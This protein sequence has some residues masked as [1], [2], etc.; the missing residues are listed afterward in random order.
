[1]MNQVRKISLLLAFVFVWGMP[2]YAQTPSDAN[3]DCFTGLIKDIKKVLSENDKGTALAIIEGGVVQR[4]P[5]YICYLTANE[6][7]KSQLL[8]KAEQ[9]R[10]DKQP[11]TTSSSA[12]TTS[13]VSKG[14]SPSL[15][16]FALEHGGFTQTTDGNTI[17]FRGNAVN[18]IR[19]LMKSTY[20]GS[21]ELG[22]KDPLV[23]Y[24]AKL[25]LGISF[26]ASGNQSSTAQGFVPTSNSLSGFSAKYEIYNHRDPRDSRWRKSWNQIV[27][28]LG[29]KVATPLAELDAAIRASPGYHETWETPTFRELE[30]LPNDPM[31]AQIQKVLQ[32]A[33][34]LF[35]EHYWNLLAVQAAVER[36][37]GSTL[38]YLKEEDDLLSSIRKTPL[39]TVEYNFTRQLTTNNQ[40][41]IATQPNQKLP[42]LSNVNLVLEKGLAGANAPELTLNAGGT[43]F[44]SANSADPN[45]GRVRDYRVSLQLDVPLKEIQNIGKPTVSLSG[46]F[47][48]LLNEPLG[49]KV[50][51]N[52][53]AIDRRGNIGVFQA[54]LSVP[55]KDSG[56][57][58][59][60]SFTYAS[61]TEL[62]KE[63]DV[64]GNIGITFDLDTLFSKAK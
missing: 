2:A 26:D 34:D 18:S 11:G 6:A 23:V 36:F 28:S 41:I 3:A 15:F 24:L 5:V 45:R 8:G 1:M 14:S 61:R 33:G 9:S 47:L 4:W 57:K 25:S 44:D 58:I 16:G 17:T 40:S 12:G 49:Q 38:T 55:V 32:D 50:T 48:G 46:Q 27:A 62:I 29:E 37:T 54:K 39:V 53:V 13:L 19:A 56:V 60:I 22:E 21:Y 52:G 59:P 42:A 43:W 64:R 30:A 63:K 10:Q 35:R 20:L 7:F 31:E 51:L